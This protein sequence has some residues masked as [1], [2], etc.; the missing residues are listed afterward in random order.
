MRIGWKE[1][2]MALA[3]LAALRSGCNSRPTGSVIVKK[4]RVIATG[5]N[6]SLPGQLQCT[7][8]GSEYCYKRSK[9][10]DDRGEAKY[11]ECLSIHGEQNS[12]NQIAKYG[13]VNLEGSEIYCTLFPCIFCMKNIASVGIKKIYYEMMYES[14]DHKRDKYWISKANEYKLEVEKILLSHETINSILKTITGITS[15]RRL[16]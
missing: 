13:G 16:K 2:F 4:N 9:N 10:I 11:R 15:I 1:Y 6:G 8:K 5:Y 14:N 12:M 7:D 3:K